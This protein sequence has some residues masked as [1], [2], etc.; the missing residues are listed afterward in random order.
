[1]Q[2]LKNQKGEQHTKSV[3]RKVNRLAIRDFPR[4]EPG[5]RGMLICPG[6]R[7]PALTV[8]GPANTTRHRTYHVV[9]V[10]KVQSVSPSSLSSVK[11]IHT[12][13]LK[14]L[15]LLILQALRL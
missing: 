3:N 9:T 14:V 4:I 2:F 1:M 10:S 15:N 6:V 8:S 5:T 13:N 12:N 7:L 11:Y